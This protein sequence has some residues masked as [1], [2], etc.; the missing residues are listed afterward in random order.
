MLVVES[1]IIKGGVKAYG[2]SGNVPLDTQRG[3]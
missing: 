3:F 2:Y 1:S